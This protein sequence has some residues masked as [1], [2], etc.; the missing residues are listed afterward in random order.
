MARVVVV[1]TIWPGAVGDSAHGR[2][3]ARG[4]VPPAEQT[5]ASFRK[6]AGSHE[7]PRV[8]HGARYMCWHALPCGRL[9]VAKRAR[10]AVPAAMLKRSNELTA[11][12]GVPRHCAAQLRRPKETRCVRRGVAVS[13]DELPRAVL[14]EGH[15][16]GHA[17]FAALS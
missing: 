15:A 6:P 16:C 1:R 12:R 17:S 10:C 13:D 11:P 8:R 3:S 7:P 9:L 5:M 14:H 4:A 2:L